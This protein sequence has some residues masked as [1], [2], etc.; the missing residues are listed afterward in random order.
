MTDTKLE[1]H[2]KDFLT[3]L[4]E[5][6]PRDQMIRER[7]AELNQPAPQNREDLQRYL[8][9]LKA[10]YAESL[11]D[12]YE[13]IESH[14]QAV[15]KLTDEPEITERVKNIMRLAWVESADVGNLI[16]SIQNAA[17]ETN[18]LTVAALVLTLITV[19]ARGLP[20]QGQLEAL[21]LDL[22]AYCL[23]R[24]PPTRPNSS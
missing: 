19:S 16:A 7:K 4:N 5:R 13:R 23:T 10:V 18:L 12:M 22:T 17:M 24:F 8:D 6:L 15:L 3:A 2:I 21:V 11:G 20:R 14:G 1:A 9:D